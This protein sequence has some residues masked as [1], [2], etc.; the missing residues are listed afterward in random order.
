MSRDATTTRFY[1]NGIQ[2]PTTYATAPLKPTDFTIG[3]QNGIRFFSGQIDDVRVY[4][5]ALT[6]NEVTLL[7]RYETY[8]LTIKTAVELN[9]ITINNQ[10]Y[11]IQNSSDMTNWTNVGSPFVGVGGFTNKFF[12][13]NGTNLFYRLQLQ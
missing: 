7:F 12:S 5:R 6:S 11:Q 8:P 1:I 10:T 2:T 4:N 3:S 13:V 9:W